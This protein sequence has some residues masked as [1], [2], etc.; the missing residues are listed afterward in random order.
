VLLVKLADRLHNMR[1]CTSSRKPEKT[2]AL[3][4]ETLGIYA[5]PPSASA[6]TRSR[7]N[8]GS[9]LRHLNAEAREKHRGPPQLPVPRA[10]RLW[11]PASSPSCRTS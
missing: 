9:L 1:T 10:A 8:G 5:P 2:R 6:S 3:A 7:R 11:S 4:L